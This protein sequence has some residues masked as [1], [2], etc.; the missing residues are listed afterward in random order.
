M[1]I[2]T[3]YMVNTNKNQQYRGL[4]KCVFKTQ[5]DSQ[6]IQSDS[7]T[8]QSDSQTIQSVGQCKLY[9][10]KSTRKQIQVYWTLNGFH[11]RSF[12]R[13]SRHG[14]TLHLKTWEKKRPNFH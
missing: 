7:Q 6:K 9:I 12:Y 11:R 2:D 8:I 3:I 4:I 10:H 1:Y 5:S 13:P 14:A